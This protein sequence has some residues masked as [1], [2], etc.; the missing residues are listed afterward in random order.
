MQSFSDVE[1][2]IALADHPIYGLAGA[3]HT[4]DINKALLAAKSIPAGTVWVNTFGELSM[5]AP[6]G[7]YKQS[8]FGRDYGM[9]GLSKYMTTKTIHIR[10][11]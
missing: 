2:G 11:S 10:L 8:G 4:S 5:N 3:V 7:G 1:E 9:T 6:F